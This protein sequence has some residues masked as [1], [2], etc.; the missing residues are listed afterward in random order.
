[1]SATLRY[2]IGQDFAAALADRIPNNWDQLS[3][4]MARRWAGVGRAR[5]ECV[6]IALKL[7]K[8][9]GLAVLVVRK[10]SVLMEDGHDGK[11]R[12]EA[13]TLW[14][15]L[16]QSLGMF[17]EQV[18]DRE[19]LAAIEEEPANLGRWSAYADWLAEK[20]DDRAELLA[21]VLDP[22]KAA[23]VRYGIPLLAFPQGSYK[24]ADAYDRDE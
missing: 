1:M 24:R 5:W 10:L 18:R 17:G 23:K 14:R 15:K 7:P 8:Q 6:S 20:G 21:A 19:F 9:I 16:C 12:K 4:K 3:A 22:K 13:R 2:D 11:I